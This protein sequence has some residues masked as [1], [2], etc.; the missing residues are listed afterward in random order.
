M[1]GARLLYPSDQVQHAGIVMEA[2]G[3]HHQFRLCAAGYLGPSG[4]LALTR[5]VSAVTAAC[6]AL[7]RAVYDE[8]GGLD[9]AFAVAFGDVDFCLRVAERGYRIVC[10][11]FA[12]LYHHESVSR[13]Y[14]DTPAKQQRFTGELQ[15]LRDRW[16]ASLQA[17][18]YAHPSLLFSWDEDGE[19][20]LPRP[21]AHAVRTR[22]RSSI[23]GTPFA[24]LL[25]RLWLEF[26][27]RSTSFVPNPL[28]AS[29][30]YLARYPGVAAYRF[31]PYHHYRRH[32]VAEGRDPNPMF[33][34][35]WYLER[36]PDVAAS[37]MNPLDHYLR[38]GA[39]EGR[40][41]KPALQHSVV[42]GNKS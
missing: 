39:S 21:E 6:I 40:D 2:G 25:S 41:P 1:V 32:G 34:T 18:Q 8:V 33:D 13:G 38:R 27:A 36:Y 37:G 5:S 22:S 28:F 7:R 11:P 19:W 23:R 20:G 26:R 24:S 9:E 31:G 15:L 30:W 42:P 4:E 14:E 3:P 17:D 29:S 12:E 35:R 16:E 10:T